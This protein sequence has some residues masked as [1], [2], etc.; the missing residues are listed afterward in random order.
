MK[1]RDLTPLPPLK[2]WWR[3]TERRRREAG[4]RTLAVLG[5]LLT[6]AASVL[7]GTLISFGVYRIYEPAGL[8]VGG[9]VVW[10][11]QWS[12]ERDREARR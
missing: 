6:V 7:G 11:L 9:L 3:S 8:M 12:H 1:A 2:R 5:G 10:L 4:R